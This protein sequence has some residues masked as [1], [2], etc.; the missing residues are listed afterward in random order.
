MSIDHDIA[1][2][3][4]AARDMR[5]LYSSRR[6]GRDLPHYEEQMTSFEFIA[7]IIL[8]ALA[9]VMLLTRGFP[10]APLSPPPSPHLGCSDARLSNPDGCARYVEVDAGEGNVDRSCPREH[11]P[12]VKAMR[13]LIKAPT[14]WTSFRDIATLAVRYILHRT[15]SEP[16]DF[17]VWQVTLQ[18]ICSSLL[19]SPPTPGIDYWVH[20]RAAVHGITQLWFASR[21]ARPTQL[22]ITT[23]NTLHHDLRAFL[24]DI[25]RFPN[26]IDCM[27][28]T[29][30]TTWRVVATL[31]AHMYHDPG[32][33][34]T[35]RN[36]YAAIY[37]EAA[38]RTANAWGE[39]P[40]IWRLERF[41]QVE[42]S[43]H[44]SA[45]L[46]AFGYGPGV[47][48]AWEWA[49]MAAGLIAAAILYTFGD[50][51]GHYN[52]VKGPRV[53]DRQGWKGWKVTKV[54]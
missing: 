54:V 33:C 2:T 37:I 47:C 9:T 53:G 43:A 30:E 20:L 42:G 11:P 16:F 38:Q 27:I 46:L 28:P 14:N 12:F 13:E 18:T 1:K 32:Y 29:Y 4:N 8:T 35:L 22:C 36:L 51:S 48:I 26:P 31:I 5:T 7:I 45:H 41:I 49:P 3:A 23:S 10:L 24:P 25:A 39:E 40:G 19:Q 21:A 17:F 34:N 50:P 15:E 6:C 44:S 52:I